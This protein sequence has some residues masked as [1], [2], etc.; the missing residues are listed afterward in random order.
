[1]LIAHASSTCDVC[2]E[3]YT[4]GCSYHSIP[5]GKLGHVFC[6]PCL[7]STNPSR[8]PLC[9]HEF[10]SHT[11]RKLHLALPAPRDAAA[12]NLE[13]K[14]VRSSPDMT[15]A[16]SLSLFQ[17]VQD[18]LEGESQEEVNSYLSLSESKKLREDQFLVL[19]AFAA[20]LCGFHQTKDKL[21][22]NQ[23]RSEQNEAEL[24]RLLDEARS[25]PS[26]KPDGDDYKM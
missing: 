10:S 20:V 19:R 25:V 24:K 18:W 2:L 13:M 15:L 23:A 9:R 21:V 8:C 26:S 11:M 12:R 1:M 16:E 3:P 17:E 4:E 14:L 6:L 5:C 22:Q 7:V